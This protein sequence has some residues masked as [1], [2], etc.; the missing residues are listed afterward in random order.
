[1]NLAPHVV[2]SPPGAAPEIEWEEVNCPLC[3]SARR[4]FLLEAP[5][6]AAGAAGLWF[7]VVR[8][9]DCDLCYTNPRP[10]PDAIGQFYPATYRPHQPAVPRRRHR[11]FGRP[12]AQPRWLTRKHL[13]I[14]PHGQRR[15]L[16]FGCG[17]GAFLLQMRDLGWQ[18]T[19]VDSCRAAVERL[20]GTPGVRVFAGT[21]PHPE[22]VPESF[23]VITMWHSLEHVHRPRQVLDAAFDLLAPGGRLVVAVPNITSRPFRRFGASWYGLD[24][25]RHLTHF[26][27]ATLYKMLDAC[28][29]DVDS[30]RMV[31]HSSW[32]RASARLDGERHGWRLYHRL[33]Q[34]R[35]LSRLLS[36]YDHFTYQSDAMLA[37]A[38]KRA[39]HREIRSYRLFP[40]R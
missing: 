7:A 32:L 1:M 39:S 6:A 21:L 13:P 26:S 4:Q 37:T 36:W 16:D 31:R 25:P 35:P 8:C 12:P 9:Q 22:L 30:L 34:L 14:A 2:S 5:D 40:P 33:L 18:V 3:D 17:G 27:P 19:G 28:G 15:L 20:R 23:D 10:S 38:N 11:W 24:L 29:F